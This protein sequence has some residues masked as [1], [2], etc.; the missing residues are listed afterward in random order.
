MSELL[1]LVVVFVAYIVQAI[2]GFAG[3]MLA[4]PLSIE[5]I[6]MDPARIILNIVAM[7]ASIYIVAKDYKKINKEVLKYALIWMTVGMCVARMMYSIVDAQLLLYIYGALIIV[8]SLQKIIMK[9]DIQLPENYMKVVL[10]FAGMVQ[11]LFTSGGPLLVIYL[12]SKIKDK[13]EF[14]VTVSTIWIFLGGLFIFQN[15]SLTTASDLKLTAVAMVPLIGG[16]LL[17]NWI[18]HRISQEKFIKIT[19]VLLLISGV[20][21]YI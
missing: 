14:R 6:G 2:S 18:H 8:V 16:V 13:E 19:S 3:T 10:F 12:V 15:A 7:V 20:S 1:F 21:V 9:R 4:M 11:G 5:L 17:G